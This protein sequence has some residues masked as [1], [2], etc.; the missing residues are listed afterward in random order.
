MKIQN[1]AEK[2]NAKNGFT[3]IEILVYAGVLTVVTV[4]VSSIFIWMLSSNT[5]SKVTR[6]TLDN[7]RR[8]ME[9]MTY[10]IKEAK[11]VYTPTTSSNQLSLETAKYLPSGE[12]T[13]YIDFYL[14]GTRLCLKK[15][16]QNPIA[17][18]SD[19]VEIGNL[20]FTQTNSGDNP[21]IQ[22]NLKV[23]YKN[24]SNRPEYKSSVNLTSTV[25]VRNY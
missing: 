25:S 15:E 4:S 20:T 14:C 2:M 12:E 8:A 21:A 10:E 17:L 13:A 11:S 23:D 9:I 3:L 18:T 19:R 5:K 6:E 1:K 22:I 7:A 24:S 16:S